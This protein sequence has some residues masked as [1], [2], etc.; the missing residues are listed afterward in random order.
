MALNFAVDSKLSTLKAGGGLN[1]VLF[2]MVLFKKMRE[3]L[4]GR[5]RVMVTGSAPIAGDVLDFLK[6]CFSAPI[7]E[8]YGMTETS[9]GSV[10]TFPDDPQT[11]I[12]G[13]PLQNVKI[14]LRDIPEMNYFSTISKENPIPKGEVMLWG[15]SIMSGYFKNPEKTAEA[16]T[17]DGWLLSGDVGA[18]QPNG[19]IKI[20]DRAKNIFKLSQGEYIAP[21]K[22]ENVYVKSQWV[23]QIWIH[24]DSLQNFIIAFVVVSMPK[25]KEWCAANGK[26]VDDAVLKDNALKQ[27]VLDDLNDHATESK[28]NTLEKP[29]QMML[30]KEPF[31]IENDYLT[32]TMKMKRNIAKQKLKS[33]IE[34][35]YGMSMMRPSKKK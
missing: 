28:F 33:E 29:A 20:I 4:G 16:L 11:G 14:K 27:A 7:C 24:G 1:H 12:V 19:A 3:L 32:P 17:K 9:A 25:V 13:G 8:G 10:I 15:P 22:L 21:E 35:L 23:D 2:D 5:V 26:T 18:I 31:S 34:E 6:I 30:M